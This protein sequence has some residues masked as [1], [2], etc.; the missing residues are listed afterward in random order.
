LQRSEQPIDGGLKPGEAEHAGDCHNRQYS[1]AQNLSLSVQRNISCAEEDN[2]KRSQGDAR[3]A[4]DAYAEELSMERSA[5]KE[6]PHI[7]TVNWGSCRIIDSQSG[8]PSPYREH[9][10]THIGFLSPLP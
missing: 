8:R 7:R 9:H 3:H 4:E 6:F 10:V 2:C 1:Q 5:E